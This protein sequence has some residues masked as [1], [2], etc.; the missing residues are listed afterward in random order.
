MSG[1]GAGM[2]ALGFS[3]SLAIVIAG[4]WF[5][6]LCYCVGL[7]AGPCFYLRRAPWKL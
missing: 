6:A 1:R 4:D 7:V 3:S 5:G 2:F